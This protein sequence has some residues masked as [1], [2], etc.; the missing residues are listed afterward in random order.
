M[1]IT[2]FRSWT[3]RIPLVP[4]LTRVTTSSR[5]RLL[6]LPLQSRI[7]P[8]SGISSFYFTAITVVLVQLLVLSPRC[9]L[10]CSFTMGSKNSI[11]P[12][13]DEDSATSRVVH[14]DLVEKARER[15]RE[16]SEDDWR[17]VLSPRRFHVTRMHGTERAFTGELYHHKDTGTLDLLRRTQSPLIL[18]VQVITSAPAALS[19]CSSPQPS[20]TQV[21]VGQASMRR[22]RKLV[23][24]MCTRSTMTAWACAELR[25]CARG[26]GLI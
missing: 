2:L 4:H 7:P 1:S 20:L 8:R 11:Y 19:S 3:F 13:S 12:P 5:V 25:Y 14:S 6:R 16:M 18:S 23:R 22:R 10:S 24:I 17:K 21:L 26:V 9:L 15:P